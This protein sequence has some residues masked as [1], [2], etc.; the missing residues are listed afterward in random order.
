MKLFIILLFSISNCFADI[1]V[2][3]ITEHLFTNKSVSEKF[4]N[5]IGD[6]GRLIINPVLE[7]EY[8]NNNFFIG[9]NSIGKPMFGYRKNWDLYE[10]KIIDLKFTTGLYY[11][12]FNHF[13]DRNINVIGYENL[14][15]MIGLDLKIYNKA[16]F[17]ISPFLII[18][19]YNF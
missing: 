9:L 5:K 11:Q 12:N 8:K 4:E 16:G 7:Y 6:Q 1:H 15:P 14:T 19:Y 3:S 17:I 18:F 2:G 13:K 10:Y